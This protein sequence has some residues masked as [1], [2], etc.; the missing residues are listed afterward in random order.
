MRRVSIASLATTAVLLAVP[1]G[2]SA[3]TKLGETFDPV[4]CSEG[5][6]Q[7]QSVSPGAPYQAPTPGV[8]TSWSFQADE[9]PPTLKFKVAR[10]GPGADFSMA[11]AFT[12]VGESELRTPIANTLN[13]YPTR[14][15]VQ[16]GDVIGFFAT[17]A[18]GHCDVDD[19]AYTMHLRGGDVAPGTTQTFNPVS[20]H[21]DLSALLEPDCDKDGL[22]DET[23]DTNLPTPP[24]PTQ[25]TCKGQLLTIVGTEGHDEIVGTPNRDVIG[26]LAGNDKVRGLGGK[27]R[28]CGG[29]N[30]DT[31]K[32][33]KAKDKL[34]GQ[35]GGDKLK[36]GG[37]RDV[38]KGGK[39]DDSASKCEVEKSI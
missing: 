6:T 7:L 12:V 11:T 21:L 32:G 23:Q 17:A 2:A 3:A 30:K 39:G 19:T 20:I 10:P 4:D 27:D 15:P 28:I 14:I 22:G 1:S 8:I 13:T 26:A 36:G 31:L 25:L 5:D 37:A 24:C 18:G 35:R 38:C 9:L 16:A 34:F 33:G 29:R